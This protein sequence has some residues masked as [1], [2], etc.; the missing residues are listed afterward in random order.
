[1]PFNCSKTKLPCNPKA[2]YS[3]F[4]FRSGKTHRL[5]LINAGVEAMQKFSIDGMNM[6]VIANDFVPIEPYETNLVS[7]GVGQRADVL[8][9]ANGK[10]TDS[11]WM[12]SD[13]SAMCSAGNQRHAKAAIY[14]EKADTKKLPTTK[15]LKYKETFCGDVSGSSHRHKQTLNLIVFRRSLLAKSTRFTL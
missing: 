11:V 14:Y 13:I 5:R 4:K 15:A 10:P 9:K 3:K 2:E 8:V 7:L 1:M 12:R 6:T